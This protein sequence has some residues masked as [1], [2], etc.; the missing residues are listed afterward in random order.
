MADT[1]G[2]N[3]ED[4]VEAEKWAHDNRSIVSA[5]GKSLEKYEDGILVR[6]IR[7][8]SGRSLGDDDVPPTLRSPEIHERVPVADKA[9]PVI[10]KPD[11]PLAKWAKK[12]K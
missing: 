10:T 7:L 8:G 4:P 6:V 2:D 9:P 12:G 1:G 5:D 11:S 3:F